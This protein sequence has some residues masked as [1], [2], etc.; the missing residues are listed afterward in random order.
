MSSP[1]SL[2]VAKELIIKYMSVKIVPFLRGSPGVGKSDIIREIAKEFNLKVIDIRLAS[3]DPTSLTGLPNVTIKNT[4]TYLPLD[5]YPLENDPLPMNPATGKLYSGWLIFFDEF[6]SAVLA[7]QK[8]AYKVILDRMVGMHKL[9]KNVAMVCAGNLQTDNALTTNLGTAM[10][11]RL[12]HI[13]LSKDTSK[14]WLD[15][16]TKNHIDYRITAFINYRP[17]A[18]NKFKPDHTEYTFPCQRTWEFASRLIVNDA[19]LTK[20]H[21]PLIAGVIGQGMAYEF[22]GFTEVFNQLP[23]IQDILSNPTGTTV[24][25]DI[26]SIFATAGLLANHANNANAQPIMTYASRLPNEFTMLAMMDACARNPKFAYNE[27][28]QEWVRNNINDI[29]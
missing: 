27:F 10:Q 8:A 19:S 3:E 13:H 23:S 20:Q 24:P 5:M 29:S 4:A 7:T 11:S 25:T 12:A 28:V 15:W 2:K 14:E 6:N 1:V 16:A 21:M 18:L 26:S 17:D 22:I 9:H